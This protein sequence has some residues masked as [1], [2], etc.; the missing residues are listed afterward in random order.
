MFLS[1]NQRKKK[2]VNLVPNMH[3][4]KILQEGTVKVETNLLVTHP[5]AKLDKNARNISDIN[6]SLRSSTSLEGQLHSAIQ[7]FDLQARRLKEKIR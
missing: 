5:N 4:F 7:R 6:E 1:A 3:V 2:N